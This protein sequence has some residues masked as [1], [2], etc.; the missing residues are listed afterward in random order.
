MKTACVSSL[1]RKCGNLAKLIHLSGAHRD[2]RVESVAASHRS[3]AWSVATEVGRGQQSGYRLRRFARFRQ[4]G[5]ARRLRVVIGAKDQVQV[6]KLRAQWAR[7]LYEVAGVEG[8]C[9]RAPQSAH[10]APA[11]QAR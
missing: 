5:I 10:K 11:R 4:S 7:H 3:R 8:C 9:D 2:K 1:K 6:S